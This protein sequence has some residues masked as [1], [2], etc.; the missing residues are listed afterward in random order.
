MASDF[1]GA[2]RTLKVTVN[3]EAVQG[4]RNVSGELKNTLTWELAYPITE[5]GY[6]TIYIPAGEFYGY[7][8]EDNQ[9]FLRGIS[10]E[11]GPGDRRRS[12]RIHRRNALTSQA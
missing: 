12:E 8:E 7:N 2:S 1:I 10:G 4:I 6:Y 11:G 9:P 5:P 3:G